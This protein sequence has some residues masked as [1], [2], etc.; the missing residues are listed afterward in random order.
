MI[1]EEAISLIQTTAVEAD[2]AKI[3]AIPG[4]ARRVIV[5]T[6][7]KRDF[8]DIPAPARAHT[9]LDLQSVIEFIKSHEGKASVWHDHGGVSVL[10]DDADRRDK[11][12]FALIPSR[13]YAAVLMM[14]NKM[15]AQ[16]DLVRWLRVDLAGAVDPMLLTTF[17]ALN[18]TGSKAAQSTIQHD[19]SSLGRQVEAKVSGTSALPEEFAVTCE[20]Y[21]NHDTG[22]Q[23]FPI[24]IDVNFEEEKFRLMPLGECLTKNVQAA[25]DAIHEALIEG[26][27]D[28]AMVYFGRP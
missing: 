8:I 23:T 1:S 26:L 17:R 12:N 11:L 20:L 13:P 25:Q 28:N 16:A 22:L 6:G 27:G 2:S 7:G 21:A 5:T 19:K 18:F 14:V 4:D 15:F 3:V 9:V 24:A 10:L